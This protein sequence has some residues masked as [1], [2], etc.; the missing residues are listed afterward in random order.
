VVHLAGEVTCGTPWD[1]VVKV[2][3]K[4]PV[5]IEG[6]WPNE[7][8]VLGDW[9]SGCDGSRYKYHHNRSTP[10]GIGKRPE[11]QRVPAAIWITVS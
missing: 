8:C 7:V 10:V 3:G 6:G 5:K 2:D 11:L 1:R 9:Y 4:R